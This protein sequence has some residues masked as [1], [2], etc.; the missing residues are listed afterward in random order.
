MLWK[1]LRSARCTSSLLNPVLVTAVLGFIGSCSS[2]DS[3][4]PTPGAYDFLTGTGELDIGSVV[5][6]MTCTYYRS[7]EP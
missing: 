4:K 3:H 2:N 1:V 6:A 7:L 5:T